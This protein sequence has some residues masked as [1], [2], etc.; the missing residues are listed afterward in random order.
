MLTN[1]DPFREPAD[2]HSIY[3]IK[4]CSFEQ[5]LQPLRGVENR[6]NPQIEVLRTFNTVFNMRL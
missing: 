5:Y 6:N 4:I 1:N 3:T 2:K